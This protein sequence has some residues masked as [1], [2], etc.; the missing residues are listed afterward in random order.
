MA[1]VGRK[2]SL[3]HTKTSQVKKL[4]SWHEV[5][6]GR[7][8]DRNVVCLFPSK[9]NHVRRDGGIDAF[10]Y[11]SRHIRLAGVALCSWLMAFRTLRMVFWT[12][13]EALDLNSGLPIKPT[14]RPISVL[15]VSLGIER[16]EYNHPL[17]DA[18]RTK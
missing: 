8:Q 10:L 2:T 3:Q 6:V 16:R 18:R 14:R 4:D 11:R 5:S 17:V 9:S 1:A 13:L 7:R 15:F 12:S